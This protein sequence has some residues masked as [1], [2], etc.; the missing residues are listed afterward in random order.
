MGTVAAAGGF[1]AALPRRGC[2]RPIRHRWFY[3]GNYGHGDRVRHGHVADEGDRPQFRAHSTIGWN[4]VD[5]AGYLISDQ[6]RYSGD[7]YASDGVSAY[8]GVYYL[9]HR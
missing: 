2:C 8:H 6:L 5:T 1:R 7:V 4:R 3:L 9:D